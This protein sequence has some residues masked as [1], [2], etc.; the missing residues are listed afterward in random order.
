MVRLIYRGA[1]A[2]DVPAANIVGWAPGEAREIQEDLA[3]ELL[4][5]GDFAREQVKA[6]KKDVNQDID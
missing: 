4:A 6:R 1:A 3:E 2:I 5:R